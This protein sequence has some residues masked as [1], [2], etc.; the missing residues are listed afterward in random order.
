[1]C[2]SFIAKAYAHPKIDGCL[3]SKSGDWSSVVSDRSG[4]YNV[5][6]LIDNNMMVLMVDY[7]VSIRI[8]EK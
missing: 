1:M 5:D 7:L 3:A 6:H 4:S 8:K 2:F